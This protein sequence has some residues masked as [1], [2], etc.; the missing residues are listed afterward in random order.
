MELSV[1]HSKINGQVEIPGSKSHTIRAIV[2]ASLAS[3]TSTIKM[4]LVSDDTISCL[5]AASILGAWIK[6][7]D[8]TV[9]RISGTGG[10]LLQPAQGI[11]NMGN[12]G[13][14]LRMFTALTTLADFPVT[15][16]GDESLRTREMAPLLES[17]NAMGAKIQ[18]ENGKC[19]LTITGPVD[20][21]EIPVDGKT[22]QYLSA[23]LLIAPL[24][25]N[26]SVFHVSSLNEKPYV[27]MT[28]DW[29]RRQN[30]Q[31][32]NNEDYSCFKVAGGQKYTPFS[33][34]IPVDFSTASF[35]LLAAAVT[36]GSLKVP[37]LDF[38]DTQGDKVVFEHFAKMGVEIETKGYL[39]T[40][41]GPEK[42]KAFDVDLNATPDALPAFAVAAAC[43]DGVSTLRNAPQARIKE[44]DRIACMTAELRKM[45]I[46]V[47]ELPDG[48][49][50]TGGKL[51]C[52]KNLQSYK[53]HRIAM[54][55]AIAA[56]TAKGE[57]I[58]HD[59]EC[60]SVTYPE[61]IRDFRQ[62]GAVFSELY[63]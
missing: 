32:E 7:G 13:T 53:D 48:M 3:G 50:I 1:K 36:G 16:D 51:K 59:A 8:D 38:S 58:I 46:T 61:F 2:I 35:P 17:L 21:A 63:D 27:G 49:V 56:M 45:G 44:T 52:C 20:G 47:E 43:A 28:L 60:I 4:P 42:L 14:G 62:T 5:K 18:T 39:T 30:I 29:M 33:T 23:L 25:K 54:S 37:N 9:W 24:L 19:P 6:R 55:L 31:V 12:S 40:I 26:D 34:L 10:H 22:S 57:S 11:L 41:K 15:F